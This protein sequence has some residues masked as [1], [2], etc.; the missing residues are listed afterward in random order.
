MRITTHRALKSLAVALAVV[1]LAASAAAGGQTPAVD[2]RSPD[3]QDAALPAQTVTAIDLRSPDARDAALPVGQA[4]P[5][6][7]GSSQAVKA[8]DSGGF[9]WGDAG[10]GAGGIFALML[11]GIGGAFAVSHRHARVDRRRAHPTV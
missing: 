10:I 7:V 9:D 1:P 4:R 2:L 6:P 8:A 11:I 3:A 5:A